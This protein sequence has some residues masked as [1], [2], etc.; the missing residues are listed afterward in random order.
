LSL[1]DPLIS[2]SLLRASSFLRRSAVVTAASSLRW[3]RRIG[4]AGHGIVCGP[5]SWRRETEHCQTV[6]ANGPI[7]AQIDQRRDSCFVSEC[8][9]EFK[10]FFIKFS[11]AFGREFEF[12]PFC[13]Y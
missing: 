2:L 6:T 7:Q 12:Y 10:I 13:T 4:G 8:F 5:V 1:A 11:F 3:A 9:C